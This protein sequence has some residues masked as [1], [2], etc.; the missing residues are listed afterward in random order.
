M[1]GKTE[2][3][4]KKREGKLQK[5]KGKRRKKRNRRKER[6]GKGENQKSFVFW[7]T[8]TVRIRFCFLYLFSIKNKKEKIVKFPESEWLGDA[9]H[10]P[11]VSGRP[12]RDRRRLIRAPRALS[13]S[14]NG[15]VGGGW[16][17]R[18]DPT[19]Q[20]PQSSGSQKIPRSLPCLVPRRHQPFWVVASC[21]LL[22]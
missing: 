3:E 9:R 22:P 15:A 4:R 12:P 18:G 14:R 2:K 11:R 16:V 19:S 20:F 5:R 1:K 13:R 21:L 8:K 10:S 17:P 6:E 7:E